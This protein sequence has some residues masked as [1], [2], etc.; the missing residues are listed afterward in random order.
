MRDMFI[1]IRKS[2]ERPLWIGESIWAELT[3]AWV[4]LDY[5]RRRDQNKQNRA[6]DVGG[7]DS[8]L[9]TG[10]SV[11]HTEHIRHLKEM[12]GRELT[13]VELHSHTHKRQEDKN[14]VDERARKAYEEYTRL[15]ESQVV[16]GEGPSGG[17]ADIS[18]YHTWSQTVGGVQHGRVYCLGSQAYTYEWQTSS[19]SSF[20]PSTQEFLYTQWIATLTIELEQVKKSQANWKMQ[21]QQQQVEMQKQQAEMLEEMRRVIE[22]ISSGKS[23]TADEETESEQ[24]HFY[25]IDVDIYIYVF[26]HL[27]ICCLDMFGLNK[28]SLFFYIDIFVCNWI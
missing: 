12:L 18:D 4:S 2:G 21:M 13:S 3:S 10:G 22:Q 15:R 17:P 27:L 24:H 6:S 5:T 16:A 19:S 23:T 7:L 1:D 20:L 11:S 28:S 8:S 25:F 26:G 9:H 14:W